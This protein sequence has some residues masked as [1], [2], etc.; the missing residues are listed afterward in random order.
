MV[1]RMSD[2]CI[3][4][5]LSRRRRTEHRPC[6]ASGRIDMCRNCVPDSSSNE[7]LSYG[8]AIVT[9]MNDVQKFNF[10]LSRSG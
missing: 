6:Q 9:A 3:S 5:A 4:S 10:E 7:I 2:I 8:E 1:V